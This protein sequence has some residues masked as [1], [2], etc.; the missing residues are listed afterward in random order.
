ML[1]YPK[2]S[3]YPN[4]EGLLQCINIL[5]LCIEKMLCLNE[6]SSSIVWAEVMGWKKRTCQ[7]HWNLG[8]W[9]QKFFGRPAD[10]LFRV[11]MFFKGKR[12]RKGA[13]ANGRQRQIISYSC[14]YSVK[15]A[16]NFR[17]H[18]MEINWLKILTSNLASI[19]LNKY[20]L[21]KEF[22]LSM[23]EYEFH[24]TQLVI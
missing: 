6:G 12:K 16:E 8:S 13:W 2:V 24:L 23:A 11:R 20:L 14:R 5:V 18:S 4:V 9:S 19:N 3:R 10:F 15:G 1:R 7:G 21:Q 17:P 22:K